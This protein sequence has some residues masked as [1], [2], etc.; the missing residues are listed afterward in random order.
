M[1]KKIA[2]QSANLVVVSDMNIIDFVALNDR[3]IIDSMSR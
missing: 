2:G 3:E 1:L